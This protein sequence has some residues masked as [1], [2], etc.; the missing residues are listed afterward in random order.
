MNA[1]PHLEEESAYCNR[2]SLLHFVLELQTLH[3]Q[4]IRLLNI[5]SL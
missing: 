5:M 1:S 2:L 3:F 4:L